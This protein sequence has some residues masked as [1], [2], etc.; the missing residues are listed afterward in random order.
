MAVPCPTNPYKEMVFLMDP[1]HS[2]KKIRNKIMKSGIRKESTRLLKVPSGRE[3]QWKMWIDA[4]LWDKQN[5]I[6]IHRKLSND[7]IFPNNSNKMRNKLAEE[8][9][10]GDMLNLFCAFKEGL[11][12]KGEE[13]DCVIEMLQNTSKMISNFRDR[14]PI[15]MTDDERLLTNHQIHCWFKNW[16]EHVKAKDNLSN[17]DKAKSLMS[18]ECLEDLHSCL[19]GFERLCNNIIRENSGWSIV[20]A[21]IN[22]DSIEN[23]F[24]QHRGKLN[25]ANTNPTALQYRRNINSVILGQSAVSRKSNA[26]TVNIKCQSYA[27][28]TSKSLGKKRKN[29]QQKEEMCDSKA[30]KCIRF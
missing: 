30:I 4:Y 26:S 20:P 9:L 10:D 23:Q 14:R 27:L 3:V 18:R 6:Q 1:S 7:H 8:V 24:C 21:V 15:H 25:G 28:S 13:L 22:S 11:G 5:P 17:Q 12:Q 2:F 29:A 16:E 19:L